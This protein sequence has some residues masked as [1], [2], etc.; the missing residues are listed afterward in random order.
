MLAINRSVSLDAQEG[1][2]HW[3]IHLEKKTDDTHLLFDSMAKKRE[4]ENPKGSDCFL[5][6][7]GC[8]EFYIFTFQ[9]CLLSSTLLISG[10]SL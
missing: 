5:T 1:D 9:I 7:S 8:L 10:A 3:I 2:T 4:R 6:M